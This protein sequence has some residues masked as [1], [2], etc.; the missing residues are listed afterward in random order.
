MK[1]QFSKRLFAEVD[2]NTLE[3]EKLL[4]RYLETPLKQLKNR[5]L[6]AADFKI[7]DWNQY[8]SLFL[9]FMIQAAR[10]SKTKLSPD[11]REAEEHHLDQMLKKGED[12]LNQLVLADMQK[13]HV[14][15]ISMPEGQILFFPEAG[16]FQ[17]PVKDPGCITNFTFGFVV[18]ITPSFAIARVAKTADRKH[19]LENR[20]QLSVFSVGLNDKMQRILIPKQ[21]RE[22]YNDGAISNLMVSQREA[23]INIV[24]GTHQ[25]RKLVVEMY[26]NA[27]LEVGPIKPDQKN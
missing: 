17:I 9:Y 7:T 20:D 13:N 15:A 25:I 14:F 26:T 24:T 3:V 19:L 16:F 4:N 10:Y 11:E 1:R 6:E 22:L 27:G 21:I 5:L 23:A 2:T 18:P 8:R 12:F